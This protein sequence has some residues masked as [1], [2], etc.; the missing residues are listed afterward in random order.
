MFKDLKLSINLNKSEKKKEET[1]VALVR[2]R[3]PIMQQ[4]LY[5]AIGEKGIK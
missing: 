2:N 1:K 4:E 5:P 3:A